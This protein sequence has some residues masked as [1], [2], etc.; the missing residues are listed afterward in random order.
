LQW[1]KAEILTESELDQL[2]AAQLQH[3]YAYR[4]REALL[5]SGQTAKEFAE[6]HELDNTRFGRV[7][8]G[9]VLMRFEDVANAERNLGLHLRPSRTLGS[10]THDAG[11]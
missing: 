6:A 1:K 8:R 4:I 7:L 11:L 10:T 9:D 3:E 2:G 5:S